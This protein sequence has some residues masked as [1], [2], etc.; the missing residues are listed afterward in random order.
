MIEQ[1]W[2]NMSPF[3]KE[4]WVIMSNQMKETSPSIDIEELVKRARTLEEEN[5]KLKEEI[6]KFKR[7]LGYL[8]KDPHETRLSVRGE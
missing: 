6:A 4:K 8:S 5:A 1:E 2:N 7:L 3:A